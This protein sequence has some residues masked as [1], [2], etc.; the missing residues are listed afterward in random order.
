MPVDNV[1]L[2]I[3]RVKSELCRPGGHDNSQ[4]VHS[5]VKASIK[6]TDAS[7][8]LA[9]PVERDKHEL[10]DLAEVSDDN[11]KTPPNIPAEV[12]G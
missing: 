5:S 1:W 4:R 2:F 11:P 6:S 10:A 3:E 9:N 12:S 8:S 7:D